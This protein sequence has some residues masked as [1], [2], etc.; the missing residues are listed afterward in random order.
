MVLKKFAGLDE[1]D[2]NLHLS[3][4][5][6]PKVRPQCHHLSLSIS[7]SKMSLIWQVIDEA[8]MITAIVTFPNFYRVGELS[9]E[10]YFPA[11]R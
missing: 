4:S 2:Y 1:S 3:N 6:Y 5:S 9:S 11:P 10:K 8:R 7:T